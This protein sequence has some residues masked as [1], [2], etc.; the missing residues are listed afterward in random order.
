MK[1]ILAGMAF[2]AGISSSAQDTASTNSKALSFSGF[3]EAYYCYDFN[4]PVDNNRPFFLYSHNRHNEFNAN[5]AYVK[6][7][8]STDNVRANIA[9]A[10]GTYMNANYAAEPGVLKNIYEANVGVKIS[11]NKNLWIDAGIFSSHIGFESAHSP[12]C[13]VL[14]RSIIAENS[15][16]YESGAKITY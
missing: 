2:F 5:L 10:V 6:G 13:L 8:Y 3:V 9:I 1:N 11:K 7:T 4:R 15:P 12:S 16:Y 14:T